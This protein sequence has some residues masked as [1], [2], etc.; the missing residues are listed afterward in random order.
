MLRFL[1]QQL[2]KQSP[3]G[4]HNPQGRKKMASFD[5][6]RRSNP[7]RSTNHPQNKTGNFVEEEA[8]TH[9]DEEQFGLSHQRLATVT[10]KKRSEVLEFDGVICTKQHALVTVTQQDADKRGA[11]AVIFLCS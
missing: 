1:G 8:R 11:A 6:Q 10:S 7:P 3:F 2:I 9:L 5:P 4:S